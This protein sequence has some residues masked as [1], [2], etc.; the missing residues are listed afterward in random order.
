MSL[1]LL[2]GNH[3]RL[4]ESAAALIPYKFVGGSSR[5]VAE[6]LQYILVTL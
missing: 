1:L 6:M 2:G 4:T 5:V 3:D